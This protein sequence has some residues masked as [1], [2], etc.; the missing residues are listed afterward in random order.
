[1]LVIINN[2]SQT[3][4]K[5]IDASNLTLSKNYDFNQA[6]DSFQWSKNTYLPTVYLK[7]NNNIKLIDVNRTENF[8][9]ATTGTLSNIWLVTD[10][11]QLVQYDSNIAKLKITEKYYP[12]IDNVKKIV[13]ANE[14]GLLYQTNNELKILKFSNEQLVENKTLNVQTVYYNQY[15]QKWLAWSPWEL[16]SVGYDG[17]SELL[18]RTSE[19]M[20]F[21]KALDKFGLI[22]LG[23][24]NKLTGFNPGYYVNHDLSDNIEIKDL[25]VDIENRVINFSGKINNQSGVYKLDY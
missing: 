12:L 3:S 1:L 20:D 9:S 17:N 8:Y 21:V 2:D 11:G 23:N 18:I 25:A 13:D 24:N 14:Q 4:L 6:I 19:R 15:T 22:L 10:K 5:L 16:W 7:I